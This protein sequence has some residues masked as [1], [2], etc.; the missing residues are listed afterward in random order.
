MALPSSGS[1]SISQIKA[2]LGSSSNS[3]RTLSSQADPVKTAPDG[4]SEFRGYFAPSYVTVNSSSRV[5]RDYTTGTRNMLITYSTPAYGARPQGPSYTLINENT[6]D[7]A[8]SRY[9]YQMQN[10]G[11]NNKFVVFDSTNQRYNKISI[12][13]YYDGG[14]TETLTLDVVL[15]S[16]YGGNPYY[17]SW[18]A[19]GANIYSSTY[20]STGFN[21]VWKANNYYPYMAVDVIYEIS[22]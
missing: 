6:V 14:I 17:V 22:N 7:E 18:N 21:L 8:F 15:G 19:G 11:W 13:A 10:F 1:I 16:P 5:L 20:T 9:F 2:E 4:M 12:V 3:L